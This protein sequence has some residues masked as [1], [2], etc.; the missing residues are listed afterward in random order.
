MKEKM[1]YKTL[2]VGVIALFLGVGI[3][4][5]VAVIPDTSDNKNDCNLCP[6]VSKHQNE[7]MVERVNHLSTIIKHMPINEEEKQEISDSINIIQDGEKIFTCDELWDIL[8]YVQDKMEQYLDGGR[9]LLAIP[10]IILQYPI[11]IHWLLRCT[12]WHGGH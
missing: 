5:V 1:L 4:P 8:E 10:F 6:K 12:D 7:R 3:Q 11:G 9:I 2:V